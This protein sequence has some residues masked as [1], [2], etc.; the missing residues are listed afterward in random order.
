M[1]S[2][3]LAWVIDKVRADRA[4]AGV[5]DGHYDVA[6]ARASLQPIDLP[7]PEGTR[8]HWFELGGMRAAWVTTP[9]TRASH[10][11]LYLHG[12]GYFSGNWGSHRTLCGWLAHETGCAILFPEYRLAPEHKF[13]AAVDDAEAAYR[14]ILAAGPDGAVGAP[15]TLVVAGDS[16]GGGLA[17]ST[18]LR[19]RQHGLR[20]PD[21]A[22]LLCA[23][24]DLDERTSKFLQLTQRTRDM[25]RQY[26]RFLDD[27]RHPEASQMLCDPTGLPPLLIQTGS[28]DYCRDDNLRF[29]Q[30]AEAHGVHVTFEDWPDMIHVWQRFAP[31]LPEA[32][33]AIQRMESWLHATTGDRR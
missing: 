27:L 6:R 10:R 11:L 12:G 25:V 19:A 16:A 15:K 4:A 9:R 14:H 8:E 24:L 28:A 23:M 2:A 33:Q 20:L 7:N 29:A 18:M 32:T 31:K 26:V 21:A 17:V 30:R 3:E 1:A 22:I 5:S 13:P